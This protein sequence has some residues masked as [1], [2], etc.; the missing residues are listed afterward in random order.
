MAKK[1]EPQKLHHVVLTVRLDI[2]KPD[3]VEMSEIINEL[4]YDFED[5][6]GKA[7]VEYTDIC[8]F[9]EID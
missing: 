5:T 4:N 1:T 8:D 7:K 3:D 2:L 9:E 6:T